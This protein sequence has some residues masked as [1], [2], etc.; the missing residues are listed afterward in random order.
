MAIV[1][2]LRFFLGGG[3]LKEGRGEGTMKGMNGEM[4]FTFT[5][6]VCRPGNLV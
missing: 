5:S 6:F 4:S 1:K 3:Y 2:N